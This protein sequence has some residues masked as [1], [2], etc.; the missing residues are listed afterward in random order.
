MKKGI[1]GLLAALFVITMVVIEFS[2]PVGSAA[3]TYYVTIKN[4]GKEV[5]KSKFKGY[6]FNESC[7]DNNGNSQKINFMSNTQLKKNKQ[8]K[9][10]VQDNQLLVQAK[11]INNVPLAS[12]K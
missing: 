7:I 6:S 2:S 1:F 3:N 4:D 9:I 11:E 12:S 8:Y 5:T 10:V